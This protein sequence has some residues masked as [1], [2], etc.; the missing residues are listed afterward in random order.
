MILVDR[1]LLDGPPYHIALAPAM[2]RLGNLVRSTEKL[3][4]IMPGIHTADDGFWT[5][6]Q[7]VLTRSGIA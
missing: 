5:Q 1:K 6:V 3:Y 7:H 4:A 2:I